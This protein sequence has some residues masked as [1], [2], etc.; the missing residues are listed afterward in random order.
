MPL[1]TLPMQLSKMLKNLSTWLDQAEAHAQEQG[2]S[3]ESLT[4]ARLAE[5][6]FP[7]ARQVQIACDTAKFLVARL[8]GQAAPSNE[9][10]E[11]TLDELRAR[12]SWTREYLAGFSGEDFAG[13]D[14]AML[15]LPFL[16]DNV[17]VKA[18][19]YLEEF[20]I[21]NFYFHC[22]TA[23]SILRAQGMPLGKRIFIGEIR[24]QPR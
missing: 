8:S 2:I 18:L 7:L 16:P 21:P 3:P 9:D 13:A 6:M 4:E 1:D 11:T 15:A 5:D 20:A 12:I 14:T 22:T 17:Q 24:L 10:T 23:Y 19:D